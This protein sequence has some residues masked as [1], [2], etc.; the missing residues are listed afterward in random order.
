[1]TGSGALPPQTLFNRI[2]REQM[3]ER[4]QRS[5]DRSNELHGDTT[6]VEVLCN[7]PEAYDWYNDRFY[8]ELFYSGRVE[9][10]LVELVRLY[11]AGEH[12]CAA[13][14]RSDWQAALD[15]G[16]TEEQL[17]G[18]HDFEN[19]PLEDREKALLTLANVM[20]LT[21]AAMQVEPALYARLKKHFSDGELVEFGMIMA[22][23]T[24]MAKFIL[25]FDLLERL[26]SC[27][28]TATRQT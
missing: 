25:A 4:H 3:N 18:L 22:V 21:N 2:S 1:M 14:N 12:G 16:Y 17:E 26:R 24:G 27:P 23:L 19:A 15:A 6:F 28:F 7:A 9:R 10:K 5:W 20:A 8:S 11:L 13:C